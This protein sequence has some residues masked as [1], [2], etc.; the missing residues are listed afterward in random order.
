MT[1]RESV[2][3]TGYLACHIAWRGIL[4]GKILGEAFSRVEGLS[5]YRLIFDISLL[6][7]SQNFGYG[8]PRVKLQSFSHFI[9]KSSQHTPPI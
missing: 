5:L 3:V 8:G 4:D 9:T 6:A 2:Y 7:R 1:L